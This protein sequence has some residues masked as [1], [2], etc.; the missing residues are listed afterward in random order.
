MKL[1]FISDNIENTKCLHIFLFFDPNKFIKEL[2]QKG[3][4]KQNTELSPVKF[5]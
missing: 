4:L 1:T 3:D 5:N 2:N